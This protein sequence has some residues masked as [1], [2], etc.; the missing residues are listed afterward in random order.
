MGEINNPEQHYHILGPGA[1]LAIKILK[2]SKIFSKCQK[3]W[4]WYCVKRYLVKN[5]ILPK[6]I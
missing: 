4:K 1:I 5:G 3:G 2:E 6:L